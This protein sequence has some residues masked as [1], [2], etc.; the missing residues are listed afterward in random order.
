MNKNCK[1]GITV[2]SVLVVLL[3]LSILA[4]IATLSTNKI[5]QDT[6]KNEFTREYKLIKANTEDYIIRNSGVIDFE[7]TTF[8]ISGINS[9]YISQFD[10]ENIVDNKIEMYI[11][12]LDKIGVVSAT[13]GISEDI[14][15]IYLLSKDTYEV[16]YKK[17]YEY[18]DQIYYKVVQ[19]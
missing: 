5:L 2:V 4:G 16:Y 7:Q 18:N 8:D 12:D 9:L 11:I 19:D 13:Y 3:I 15:D 1:K 17:G 6:R 10:G 14:D